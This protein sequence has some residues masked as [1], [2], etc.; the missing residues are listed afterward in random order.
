[1]KYMGGKAMIAKRLVSVINR[2]VG[3]AT[4]CWEPFMGGGNVTTLLARTRKGVASDAH[5]SLM[6]MWIAAKKGWAPPSQ[7]AKV[8][9]EAA[10]AAPDTNPLK[11]FAGFG[12][13]FKGIWFGSYISNQLV[14]ST[15]YIPGKP[16]FIAKAVCPAMQARAAIIKTVR[17]T[18]HWEFK[19]V[20]FFDV[21]PSASERFIYADPPYE[22]T[23]GYSTGAFPH[24]LFWKQCQAWARFV[25]VIVSE[26]RCPVAHRVLLE[27]K[28]KSGLG[29][30][31]GASSARAPTER[32]FRVL[33]GAL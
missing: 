23:A 14:V 21:E 8:Q 4:P 29:G 2:E 31:V 24:E 6:A 16:A 10:K 17:A 15:T 1:M 3:A 22:G 28:R 12:C 5:P 9:W 18:M 32:L 13:S 27:M 33:P 7:L 11:A 30:N 25:P 19:C 26:Y 20:S